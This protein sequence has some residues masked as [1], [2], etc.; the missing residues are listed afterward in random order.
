VNVDLF[1]SRGKSGAPVSSFQQV[2]VCSVVEVID[3]FCYSFHLLKSLFGTCM[4][5]DESGGPLNFSNHI[6]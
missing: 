2:V 6:S 5:C 1:N 4:R 3:V